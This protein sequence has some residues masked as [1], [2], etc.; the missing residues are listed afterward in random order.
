MSTGEA[1]SQLRKV[2]GR[3]Y[4]DGLRDAEAIGK[5]S[6]TVNT[7]KQERMMSGLSDQA[8]RVYGSV[9]IAEAWTPS[10]IRDEVVRQHGSSPELRAVMG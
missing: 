9:P 10:Q 5:E 6:H 4:H 7:Q 2:Y 8:K 3:G 1:G